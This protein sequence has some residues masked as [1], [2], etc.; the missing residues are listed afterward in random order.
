[1]SGLVEFVKS[2]CLP[3]QIYLAIVL[4]NLLFALVSLFSKNFRNAKFLRMFSV[5]L[6]ITV[7]VGL[8]VTWVSN[9]FCGQGLAAIAWLLVLLPLSTLIMNVRLLL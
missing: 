7:L 1:M 3:A 8:A 5:L 6:V 2:A 4:L 9:W